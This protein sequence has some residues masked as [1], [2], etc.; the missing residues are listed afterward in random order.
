LSVSTHFVCIPCA[1]VPEYT[2]LDLNEMKQKGML[3]NH[4]WA[5]SQVRSSL[6]QSPPE[7]I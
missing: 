3:E 6:E 7:Y 4:L 5:F 2:Y 1:V